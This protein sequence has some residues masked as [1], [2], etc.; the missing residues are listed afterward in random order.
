MDAHIIWQY[1]AD[2][3]R[4]ARRLC[5]NP[6]D[7]EDVAQTALMK[8]V[9]GRQGFRGEATIRTWLHRIATNECLMLHRKRQPAGVDDVETLQPADPTHYV[10]TPEDLILVS[11]TQGE[12]LAAVADLPERQQAVVLAVDGCGMSYEEAA[13]ALG[14][15]EA[16]IRSTLFRARRALRARLA[17]G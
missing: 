3:N 2:L 8:A 1:E 12:V 4:L 6:L 7:A 17:D 5:P 11:E 10:D 16:G 14:M 9:V 13:T 15:S